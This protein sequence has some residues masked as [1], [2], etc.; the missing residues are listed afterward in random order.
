[1]DLNKKTYYVNIE[2]GEL[3][4]NATEPEAEWNFKIYA[5]DEEAARLRELF[6]ENYNADLKTYARAHV[7]Y[8]EYH[9]ASQ[10]E[11]YDSTIEQAYAMIYELGDEKAKRHIEGMGILHGEDHDL[12]KAP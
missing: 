9:R 8:L 12:G 5:T 7:P 10:N 3:L 11:E 4:Q 1:M 6:S 2:N